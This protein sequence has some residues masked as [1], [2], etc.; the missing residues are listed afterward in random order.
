[1]L[2]SARSLTRQKPAKTARQTNIPLSKTHNVHNSAE[3]MPLCCVVGGG[4]CRQ[5]VWKC[6]IML[7]YAFWKNKYIINI[8]WV[9]KTGHDKIFICLHWLM[10][11]YNYYVA[12]SS[13]LSISYAGMILSQHVIYRLAR[14]WGIIF[15][16]WVHKSNGHLFHVPNWLWLWSFKFKIWI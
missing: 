7:T 9:Y 3:N 10:Y 11:K 13:L 5:I 6:K 2:A 15:S 4:L 16:H 14:S 8:L 1:M 12:T